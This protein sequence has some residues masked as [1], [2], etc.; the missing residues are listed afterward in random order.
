MTRN[1]AARRDHPAAAALLD[2]AGPGARN[3]L[4]YATFRGVRAM[5]KLHFTDDSSS[6]DPSAPGDP[7]AVG[8]PHDDT[9]TIRP[10]DT[11][12]GLPG[13]DTITVSPLIGT[14]GSLDRAFVFGGPGNDTIIDQAITGAQFPV[15]AEGGPGNDTF[16]ALSAAATATTFFTGGPGQDTFHFSTEPFHG[17]NNVT[18]TDF[19]RH[20]GILIDLNPSDL[21]T[22]TFTNNAGGTE[23]AAVANG[24]QVHVELQ[25][26]FDTSQFH[27]TNDGAGHDVITYGH[28]DFHLV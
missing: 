13:D 19:G 11:A 3:L 21:P 10:G 16:V 1:C 4:R 2:R 24:A 15:T 6:F 23:L 5:A 20:D 22:V 25:G 9:I 17:A 28:S 26:S 7:T 12:F 18:I 8:T 27:V 14:G